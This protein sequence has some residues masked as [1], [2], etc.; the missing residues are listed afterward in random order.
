MRPAAGLCWRCCLAPTLL[1]LLPPPLLLF[2]HT[3][4]HNQRLE[5]LN[6]KRQSMVSK[7]KG[8]E[9]ELTGEEEGGGHRQSQ[10]AASCL[11]P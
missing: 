3:K 1:L 8:V 6:E 2:P 5:D 11:C 7:L 9:K 10:K 4:R